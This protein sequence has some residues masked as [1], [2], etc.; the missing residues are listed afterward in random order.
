M[1]GN[2]PLTTSLEGRLESRMGSGLSRDDLLRQLDQEIDSFRREDTRFGLTKWGIL[3]AAA[4]LVWQL[5]S[6][7]SGGIDWTQCG[8]YVLFGVGAWG[9][10]SAGGQ[11]IDSLRT[12]PE[13]SPRFFRVQR[14]LN[15]DRSWM[16]VG[17]CRLALLV[18]TTPVLIRGASGWGVAAVVVLLCRE[19]I[20]TGVGIALMYGESSVVVYRGM[21]AAPL[22]RATMLVSPLL[23]LLLIVPFWPQHPFGD[24]QPLKAAAVVLVLLFLARQYA[25][26]NGHPLLGAL[27]ELRRDVALQ[28][29]T[30]ERG[31]LQLAA[32]TEG[33]PFEQLFVPEREAV[34][35]AER[36]RAEAEAAL[37]DAIGSL[38][39]TLNES[40][41]A[42]VISERLALLKVAE[43]QLRQAELDLAVRYG[44]L[45]QRY[46]AITGLLAALQAE[47]PQVSFL[48][49]FDGLLAADGGREIL[50]GEAQQAAERAQQ[51]LMDA[52]Q[53]LGG[54]SSS[55]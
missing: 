18:A 23:N 4:G 1:E 7:V 51:V 2:A 34:L 30:P 31:L 17:L 41:P 38:T 45:A 10:L 3:V 28:R 13:K 50:S 43:E 36:G 52:H 40:A 27:E 5:L 9:L 14:L 53:P 25:E 39:G 33:E 26:S 42:R 48:A 16:K 44:Q 6:L 54:T 37:R 55:S 8:R 11:W 12:A 46:R 19:L 21:A 32:I 15:S 20:G 49:A 24:L 29:T 47:P 35:E 22:V